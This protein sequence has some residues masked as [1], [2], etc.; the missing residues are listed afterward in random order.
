[1]PITSAHLA[2]LPH[3]VKV[4]A[5]ASVGYEHIDIAAA[6]A[7]GIAVTNTPDVLTDATADTT[8][9][10]LLGA[11]RRAKEHVRNMDRAGR[12][13]TASPAISASN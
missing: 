7:R 9:L 3:S 12:R 11:C 1:M 4:L 13:R 2:R 10:L 8:M 5:T 6:N